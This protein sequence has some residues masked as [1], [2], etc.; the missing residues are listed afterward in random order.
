MDDVEVFNNPK[1]SD[2]VL[3]I[4][5][6]EEEQPHKKSKNSNSNRVRF[7]SVTDLHVSKGVLATNSKYFKRLLLNNHWKDGQGKDID[8]YEG[9]PALFVKLIKL[10]YSKTLHN[11]DIEVN[12]LFDLLLLADKYDLDHSLSNQISESL[13]NHLKSLEKNK[14]VE[15]S[16]VYLECLGNLDTPVFDNLRKQCGKILAKE[17]QD[18]SDKYIQKEVAKLPFVCLVTM[19]QHRTNYRPYQA[20]KGMTSQRRWY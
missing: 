9:D 12:E 16:K 5:H 6:E 13:I 8:I 15:L 2:L 17:Y 4:G 1:V 18:F 10:M 11:S 3:H 14:A 7:R 19:L 20:E